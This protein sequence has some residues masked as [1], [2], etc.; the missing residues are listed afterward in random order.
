MGLQRTLHPMVCAWAVIATILPIGNNAVSQPTPTKVA[1]TTPR[2][3]E[4]AHV[5]RDDKATALAFSITTG[6]TNVTSSA[7]ARPLVDTD[8]NA[9]LARLPAPPLGTTTSDWQHRNASTMRPPSA[10]PPATGKLESIAFVVPVGK[11]AADRPVAPTVTIPMS[12]PEILPKGDIGKE[13]E[14]RVRFAD[15]MVPIASVGLVKSAP[16]TITPSIAGQ[17]RWVDTSVLTFTSTAS[18]LPQATEFKVTVAAGTRALNGAALAN[19]TTET[20]RTPPVSLWTSS[21]FTLLPTSALLVLFDQDVDPARIAPFVSVSDDKSRTIA[22]HSISQA[23]AL[24]TWALNPS[25]RIDADTIATWNHRALFLAPDA[26]WPSGLQGRVNLR[27]GAPSAEGPR[28]S[29]KLATSKFQVAPEFRLI[30]VRC[31]DRKPAMKTSCGQYNNV[32]LLFSNAINRDLYH[33]T[34]VQFKGQPFADNHASGTDISLSVPDQ[35]GKTFSIS[36]ADN[37]VDIFGQTLQRHSDPEVTAV[38]ENDWYN[39]NLNAATGLQI[40][41]PRFTIPQWEVG[42]E[43]MQSVRISLYR[44]EPNDYFAYSEFEQGFRKAAPGKRVY[45]STITVGTR[46]G[47]T[48]RVDLRPALSK[49]GVGHVIAVADPIPRSKPYSGADRQVSWIQV[50]KLGVSSRIDGN[51]A[52]VWTFATD[53]AHA[54]QPIANAAVSVVRAKHVIANGSF[55]GA[56]GRA[57]IDLPIADGKESEALLIAEKDDD[58]SFIAV[59]GAERAERINNTLWYVTNDRGM[60]KPGEPLYIKGWMR[61]LQ[62]QPGAALQI[63]SS[64][65]KINYTLADAKGIRISAGELSL[66]SQGG[67]DLTAMIP[68]N[69]NLGSAVISLSTKDSTFTQYVAIEEFRAPAFA[70]QL[71]DDVAFGGNLPLFVGDQIEM[72]TSANYYSGGKLDGAA[73]R[74]D[75]TLAPVYYSPPGWSG[76]LFT[77]LDQRA[78]SKRQSHDSQLGADSTSTAAIGL[79][80]LAGMAAKLTVDATVTD[81][82]RMAIRTSSRGILVYPSSLYVGIRSKPARQNEIELVVTDI[83]GNVRPER[84]INVDFEGTVA[85]ERYRDNPQIVDRQSCAIKSAA[86][87]VTCAVKPKDKDTYYRAVARVVDSDGRGNASQFMV[88]HWAVDDSPKQ[89]SATADRAMYRPG[90]TAHI[91]IFAKDIPAVATLAVNHNGVVSERRLALIKNDTVVDVPIEPGFLPE[92]QVQVD[93][94]QNVPSTNKDLKVAPQLQRMSTTLNLAV[95]IESARLDM[96]VKPTTARVAPGSNAGFEV[97]VRRNGKPIANAEVAL[98]VVDEAILAVA[99]KTFEDPLLPFYPNIGS[100]PSQDST[101]DFLRYNDEQLQGNPGVVRYK[102]SEGVRYGFGSG[103]GMGSGSG[104]GGT[105]SR[106]STGAVTARADFRAN[107]LFAPRLNTDGNGMARATVKMPDSLTKF[108]IVALA[109]SDNGYFG[110]AESVITTTLPMNIRAVAP[111][112]LV[113]GDKFSAPFVIQNLSDKDQTIDVATRADNLRSS[114]SRGKRITVAAGERAELRFDFTTMARG[115]AT[116]SAIAV[117]GG[118]TGTVTDATRVTLPVY[119]PAT[120]E[121]FAS[122]G[123]T[124]AETRFERLQIP[125][126][127]YPDVGG[128]DVSMS[129]TQ[130]QSLVDG[131]MYVYQY[132]FECAEQRSARMLATTTLADVLESFDVANRPTQA[133]IKATSARDFKIL[134]ETQRP[135]GGWGYFP[136]D[137]TDSYVTAQVLDALVTEDKISTTTERAKAYVTKQ[138]DANLRELRKL[139]KNPS[140]VDGKSQVRYVVSIAAYQL[141][142]IASSLRLVNRG[143]NNTVVA[144]ALSLHQLATTL[145]AYPIDAKSRIL[146]LLAKNPTVTDVRAGLLANILSASRETAGAATVASAA[147]DSDRLLLPSDAKSTGLALIAIVAEAPDHTMIPKLARGELGLRKNG[148]WLTT[149]ENVS[150][151]RSMRR[152]FDVFEKVTPQFTGKVWIGDS[153]YT[154][155]VFAG[156]STTTKRAQL[157]WPSF[158][159]ANHDIAI[160]K[161]GDGRLYYRVGI[162]Y[163]PT[164]TVTPALDAGFVVSRTYI[165]SDN[166]SD[167][168]RDSNGDWHVRLGAKVVV[169]IDVINSTPRFGVALVDQLPAGFEAVNQ[170]LATAESSGDLTSSYMW[171]APNMR[172]SRVE[173]FAASLNAGSHPYQ[174]TVRATTP[175]TF[176]TAPARAEEMYAP[177]TFGRSSGFRVFVE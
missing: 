148:R 26:P 72:Q 19:P 46:T 173:V 166:P 176:F 64:A 43:A 40:L 57:S 76:Y 6:A 147:L 14:V 159:T 150:A 101:I 120:T 154:E 69:V 146:T 7:V 177:E 163:A 55:T 175:G 41:D 79:Q 106:V 145:N 139:S 42:A 16:A 167:V 50:S 151:L 102:L 142:V 174:Y 80:S 9:L 113:Q 119:A 28:V 111:R 44:V 83:D 12:A 25:I 81:V 89:F 94:M 108:R 35:P 53:P 127:I 156:R 140:S 78:N 137:D 153:A 118:A 116:I 21:N 91:S 92:I 98:I 63:P 3:I 165:A 38:K 125:S 52:H 74:W 59:S 48:I 129:S 4:R 100:S 8:T 110:K 93:C 36:I 112:F 32:E 158:T 1:A 132:P 122:Y 121:S 117:V 61:T 23:Q 143:T 136:G 124:D 144:Q 60:Y 56:D 45:D 33:S 134:A 171:R 114:G 152:Y 62:Q 30:G 130:M 2:R 85:S 103:S 99:G 160:S 49:A 75:A 67:F 88:P 172:D 71:N 104:H 24:A 10:A 138:L 51:A 65:S 107:A 149:Q 131:F 128:V 168:K 162:T 123:T 96:I 169:S 105:S 73:V 5:K 58:S 170:R 31:E 164:Q 47:A 141:E 22:T 13:I 77:P 115:P 20:F 82:D 18:R 11:P 39:P 109:S 17:W 66:T 97:S 54:M 157:A 34:D 70:L 68:N 126:N 15:P 161:A 84:T 29:T 87:A 86:A 27:T 133:E 90:D 155:G 95:D 135:D 37:V